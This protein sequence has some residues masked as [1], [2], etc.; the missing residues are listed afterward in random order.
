MDRR[1]WALEVTNAANS[2]RENIQKDLDKMNVITRATRVALG[3][4]KNHVGSIQHKYEGTRRWAQDMLQEHKEALDDWQGS[5]NTLKQLPVRRDFDFLKRPSTPTKPATDKANNDTATLDEYLNVRDVKDAAGKLAAA[6]ASFSADVK[7]LEDAMRDLMSDTVVLEQSQTPVPSSRQAEVDSLFEEVETLSKKISSDYEDVLRLQDSP[8]S[9]ATSSRKAL[10]HTRDFLPSMKATLDEL[11]QLAM[12]ANSSRHEVLHSSIQT[13][14]EISSIES[15]LAGIQSHMASLDVDPEGA[16][17]FDTINTVFQLPIAYGSTLIESIR[18]TEWFEKMRTDSTLLKEEMNMLKDEEQRRRKKWAK[19]MGELL[20]DLPDTTTI[21]ITISAPEPSERWPAVTRDEIFTYVEDLRNL[22]INDAVQQITQL[23]KGLEQPMKSRLRSMKAFKNGSIHEAGLG[24]GRS[25]V[26]LRDSGDSSK[27]LLDEKLK[28]EDKL[29]ASDSRVRKLEDLLHRQSQIGRPS[30]GN[31]GTPP[32]FERQTPLTNPLPSPR[33]GDMLSRRSSVSSR[34][35]SSNQNPEEKVLIQR[36]VSLEADVNRLQREAHAERRSSTESRDKMEEAESTKRDLM[37][38][39]EAQR[40]EFDDERQL[41]EEESHKLKIRLEE[42]EDELD[43]VQGSRDYQKLTSDRMMSELQAEL[44]QLR[45]KSADELRQAQGEAESLRAEIT[46]HRDKV[47]ALDRQLQQAKDEK[48]SAQSKNMALANQ[49]RDVEN[50]RQDHVSSLQFA[51]SQL[52]PN[53]SAPDDLAKLVKA[54][55]ILS[56]GHAIHTRGL[57]DAANLSSAE[58]KDLEERLG[59][60]EAQLKLVREELKAEKAESSSIREALAQERSKVYSLRSEL[61]DEQNE[62]KNLR[63]KFA[64]GETGSEA[65]KERVANEE[66]KVAELVEKLAVADSNVQSFEQEISMW[67]ERVQNM[68]ATET[69][70]RSK[71]KARGM[72]AKDLSQRI[73]SHNDRLIRILEQFGFSVTRQDE[74]LVIQR[75]SKV[76]ASTVLTNTGSPADVS[77]A[78]KRTLSGTSPPDHY[79]SPS[80]F[81]TLYWMS[82][83]DDTYEEDKYQTFISS[84]TRLDAD[85]AVDIITKRY[86]DVEML[87]RKY[88]KDSRAYREKSHRVQSEAHE[89]IAYRSFK[90]G[91]L[92]L[93][94]PTRNQATRPWAAFNVGAPHYFLREQDSHK[95]QSRDWLLARISKVEERIVDLSRSLNSGLR[96]QSD[97]QSVNTEASDGASTRSVDDENPFE[98]SDGLRWYMIDAYEEKPGAP[99]TPGLGK[100]TVAA[101]NVDVKGSFGLTKEGKKAK[102]SSISGN[103]AMAT[104]TLSKSLDSR[105]SSS[106]SKKGHTPSPST[107]AAAAATLSSTGEA[108]IHTRPP[109][110]EPAEADNQPGKE[111]R[112]DAQVFEE[113][114]K[115][116]LFGP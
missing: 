30:S 105:R 33:P 20:H 89:K 90:E 47:S 48:S 29:K 72:K 26:F 6:S 67:K 86:K 39:L 31:F 7:G 35:L 46:L 104:K 27:A 64:A 38:N 85:A 55:E 50:E 79:S 76:N 5:L 57:E 3:N 51:H 107:G 84:L 82:E 54:I 116:L 62:L 93:F 37:A 15:G 115:D 2:Y 52:S 71:L 59:Q 8:K 103:A 109:I 56:E 68:T 65:L 88:Q 42:T 18:R 75:A 22:G 17:A 66:Q 28:L 110:V 77:S 96:G 83:S 60:A 32:D 44:E 13:L 14:G 78:M 58:N 49:L 114:R 100:S 16:E 1:A 111:A 112:E 61:V 69:H 73:F 91:D 34:R 81:E 95:L 53:G 87:A 10:V 106:G 63:S 99:T 19:S 113:V 41:L 45:T 70:L 4:L 23:M 101:T 102:N 97:R 12:S 108:L 21:G 80:D 36:I 92:A 9:I 24:L 40:Q 43:R 11:K 74:K 25:S 94:L 98:L